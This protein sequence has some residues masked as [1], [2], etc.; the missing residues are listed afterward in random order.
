VRTDE[1]LPETFTGSSEWKKNRYDR[2][3]FY[4]RYSF[5]GYERNHVFFNRDG[6]EF[7]DFSA[8]SGLDTEADSRS[9]VLFD[10]DRD[11]WQDIALVNANAP[12]FNLYRNE[13]GDIRQTAGQDQPGMIALRFV[14]GNTSSEPTTGFAPRDGYGA[15]VEVQLAGMTLKREHRCGEGFAAQNSSTMIIGIGDRQIVERVT[16]RWPSGRR[17][18]IDNV[19]EGTLL[20]VYEREHDSP[21]QTA[22]TTA[23]YRIE[24]SGD[25]LATTNLQRQRLD[26]P[27]NSSRSEPQESELRM[28]VA[29]ASWCAAC[30]ASLPQLRYLRS[31]YTADQ[32]EMTGVPIDPND[33]PRNLRAYVSQNQPPYTLLNDVTTNQLEE[34]KRILHE[35][36]ATVTPATILTDARGNILKTLRGV[37]TAS[38]I[39]KALRET[40][41]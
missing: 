23:R 8:I 11:G 6:R 40:K 29:M 25:V 12:L 15:M 19:A 20:T 30:K 35:A 33:D 5:S 16:V 26:I 22:F 31:T 7:T 1:T 28:Y 37:P 21:S 27:T 39:A 18:Q 32:L 38:D 34:F 2:N 36:S 10:Y 3:L 24:K 4:G 9:F 41:E 17:Q 13:I 14:G